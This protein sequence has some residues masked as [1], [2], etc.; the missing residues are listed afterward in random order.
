MAVLAILV[1]L[2]FW[3]FSQIHWRVNVKHHRL[4]QVGNCYSDPPFLAGHFFRPTDTN[5]VA[6]E[7][8]SLDGQ[9]FFVDLVQKK[10]VDPV[11][12]AAIV[13]TEVFP[14]EK[15]TQTSCI[16]PK[17]ESA[18]STALTLFSVPCSRWYIF[19]ICSYFH[20]YAP[21][22]CDVYNIHFATSSI[23][24]KFANLVSR[25]PAEKT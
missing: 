11:S 13:S 23:G 20:H 3:L 15:V 6:C 25:T 16:P 12:S 8:I 14:L 18:E 21:V 1:I 2:V 10:R 4:Q 9:L 17:Y 7:S 5:K 19:M 22:F 24:L